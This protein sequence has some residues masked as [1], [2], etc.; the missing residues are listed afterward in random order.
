MGLPGTNDPSEN[1]NVSVCVCFPYDAPHFNELLDVSD[2]A[3]YQG[4]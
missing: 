1:I 3:P 2:I 4:A